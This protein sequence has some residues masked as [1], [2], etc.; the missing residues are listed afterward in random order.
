MAKGEHSVVWN[1]K[2]DNNSSVASGI[3]FYRLMS[4]GKEEATGKMLLIK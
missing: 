4:D 3:Y 2:D 1:G